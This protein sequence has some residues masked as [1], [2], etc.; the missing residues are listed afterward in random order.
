MTIPNV[1]CTRCQGSGEVWIDCGDS[2]CDC[3]GRDIQ[4]G[5]CGGT[6]EHPIMSDWSDPNSDPIGDLK[7]FAEQCRTATPK[8]F[9]IYWTPEQERELRYLQEGA[10]MR[11]GWLPVVLFPRIDRIEGT[12]ARWRSAIRYRWLCIKYKEKF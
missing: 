7:K 12:L 5:R 8:A 3:G 2:T 6:G 10:I 11:S 4:C 9:V 1:T